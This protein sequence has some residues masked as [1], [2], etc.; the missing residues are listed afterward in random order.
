MI[1][2]IPVN[3]L[4]PGMYV[5]DFNAGWLSHPF[6]FNSMLIESEANAGGKSPRFCQRLGMLAKQPGHFC[7]RLDVSLGI[8]LEPSAGVGD[9]AMFAN[10]GEDVLQHP[11]ARLMIEHVIGRQQGCPMALA[12]G[13]ETIEPGAV[14]AAKSAGAGD[15]HPAGGLL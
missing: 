13:S 6:A 15:P 1:K 11:P 8:G 7:R 10:A 2:K 4:E 14:I 12:K 3:Q 5:S 9:G